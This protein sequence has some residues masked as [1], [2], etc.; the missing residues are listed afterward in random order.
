MKKVLICFPD[1]LVREIDEYC[2][3][4][5]YVRSEFIREIIRQRVLSGSRLKNGPAK[6]PSSAGD[7]SSAPISSPVSEWAE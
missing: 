5:Y 3:R 2:K 4:Y 1:D 6:P 7:N